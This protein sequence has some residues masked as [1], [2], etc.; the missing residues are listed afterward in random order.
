MIKRVTSNGFAEI[1]FTNEMS[2]IELGRRLR[3]EVAESFMSVEV[4]TTDSED[5]E[6]VE[7]TWTV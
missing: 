3:A 4:K 7:Q 5:E 6:I 2:V 1:L